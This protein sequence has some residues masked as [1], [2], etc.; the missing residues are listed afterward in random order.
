M[1]GSDLSAAEREQRFNDVLAEY[2]DALEAGQPDDRAALL[3]RHPDL[4]DDL[5]AFFARAEQVQGLAAPLRATAT[6]GNSFA[7][8][9]SPAAEACFPSLPADQFRFVREVGRGGMGVVYEAI[10]LSLGRRVALKV[11]R[12]EDQADPRALERFRREARVVARLHH[13]NIVPIFQVGEHDG[14]HYFAMEFID[15]RGLDKVLHELQQ[16]PATV[17]A[18]ADGTQPLTPPPSA[19]PPASDAKAADSAPVLT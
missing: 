2:L 15:G 14:L 8:P 4:A 13:T 10:E 11:L 18:L 6:A 9:S 7:P 19:A 16:P 3:Q 1:A 12:R 17:N 5:R